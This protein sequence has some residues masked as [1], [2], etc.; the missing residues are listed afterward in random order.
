VCIY[1]HIHL[2][3]H[4]HVCACSYVCVCACVCVCVCLCVYVR[5]CVFV[6]VLCVCLCTCACV[7]SS[8]CWCARARA[9]VSTRVCLRVLVCGSMY[10]SA[11]STPWC[12]C[13]VPVGNDLQVPYVAWTFVQKPDVQR[14]LLIVVTTYVHMPHVHTHTYASRF[15]LHRHITLAHSLAPYICTG[16]RLHSHTHTRTHTHTYTHLVL[17]DTVILLLL[18]RSS[19]ELGNFA[20]LHFVVKEH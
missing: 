7:C 8:V 1:T 3:I 19:S 9:R 12:I 17:N 13:L 2:C 20:F 15:V 4:V 16:A 10:F 18:T 14:I 11:S 5:V 6:C